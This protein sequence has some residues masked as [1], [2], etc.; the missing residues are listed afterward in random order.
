MSEGYAL[1][2]SEGRM[3]GEG[4]VKRNACVFEVV[5]PEGTLAYL[6]WAKPAKLQRAVPINL[7]LSLGNFLV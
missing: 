2:V 1:G 4:G 5:W 6:A 7:S 3:G